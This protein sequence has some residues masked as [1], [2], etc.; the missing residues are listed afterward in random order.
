[1]KR[2]AICLIAVGVWL[3]VCSLGIAQTEPT[4]KTKEER[5]FPDDY[6]YPG[7][8]QGLNPGIAA[9]SWSIDFASDIAR[10]CSTKGFPDSISPIFR[11]NAIV[12][13][14]DI[15]SMKRLHYERE[16]QLAIMSSLL[17]HYLTLQESDGRPNEETQRRWESLRASIRLVLPLYVEKIHVLTNAK[18][19]KEYNEFSDLFRKG[20]RVNVGAKG[21][22]TLIASLLMEQA[23]VPAMSPEPPGWKP[24]YYPDK[25]ALDKLLLKHPDGDS[26]DAMVML[27]AVP[28]SVLQ[29]AGNRSISGSTSGKEK[30]LFSELFKTSESPSITFLP[31]GNLAQ[32]VVTELKVKGFMRTMISHH[33]Y[34]FIGTDIETWGAPICLNTHAAYSEDSRDNHKIQ[35]IRHIIYRILSNLDEKSGLPEGTHSKGGTNQWK[36]VARNLREIHH[37]TVNWKDFGFERHPDPVLGSIIEEWMRRK[38]G[39]KDTKVEQIE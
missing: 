21:S 36:A 12:T 28:N 7:S 1:M 2:G 5:K 35:W 22:T 23:I 20:A 4:E 8:R 33:D 13:E 32:R 24:T 37:G 30:N 25:I 39:P 17:Y 34:D 15:D 3:V 16:I 31:I 19:A 6:P 26:L 27:S 10:M 11:L 18:G 9:H 14:G 29:T 38:A